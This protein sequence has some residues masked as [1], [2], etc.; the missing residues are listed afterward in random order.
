MRWARTTVALAAAFSAAPGLA[1]IFPA[2]MAKL[3][4]ESQQAFEER[5]RALSAAENYETQ[6]LTQTN[7]LAEARTVFVGVVTAT[8]WIPVDAV[9]GHEI[10]VRPL[11]AIKGDLPGQPL[12]VRDTVFTDCGIAGGGSATSAEPGDYVIIFAELPTAPLRGDN[13]GILAKEAVLPDLYG[14]L[15]HYALV[16]L[17]SAPLTP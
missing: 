12:T 1:C 7:L 9:K 8:R 11:E 16:R 10:T 17:H 13:V 14:A 6:R 15:A 4:G 3:P 2:P 5:G